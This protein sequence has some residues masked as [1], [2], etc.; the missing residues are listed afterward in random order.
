M[1]NSPEGLNSRVDDTEE[2]IS[3]LDKRLEEI[4]Q[5]EQIKEK[6][7]KKNKVGLR[8]FWDNIKCTNI[9]I[10]GVQEGEERELKCPKL[11]TMRTV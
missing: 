10:I 6:L 11:K 2:W 7:I 5:V 8:E 9:R 3:E 4:T 1:K